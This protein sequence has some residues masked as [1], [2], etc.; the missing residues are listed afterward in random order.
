MAMLSTSVFH[1]VSYISKKEEGNRN[2]NEK[3]KKKRKK[4]SLK[5]IFFF[6]IKYL[7]SK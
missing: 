5:H 1:S 2:R 7:P 4:I 3:K 6:F